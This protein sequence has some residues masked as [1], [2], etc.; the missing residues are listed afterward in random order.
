MG[1]DSVTL[2]TVNCHPSQRLRVLGAGSKRTI[3]GIYSHPPWSSYALSFDMMA[4][5]G[6]GGPGLGRAPCPCISLLYVSVGSASAIFGGNSAGYVR[7]TLF[8][9]ATGSTTTL[10]FMNPSVP[11]ALG[12]YPE[13]DNVSVVQTSPPVPVAEQ[14]DALLSTITGVGPGQSL[15]AKVAQ[16][17]SYY[18][19]PDIP[20]T[21]AVPSAFVNEVSAQ[22]GKKILQVLAKQITVDAQAIMT[23][24]GCQN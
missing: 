14:L 18:A 11:A 3:Q 1:R 6:Y 13:I 16:A 23:T 10:T 17:Q 24:I 2:G 7:E 15:A 5:T 4:Y 19:V 9:T 12:N 22:E 8:F 21:C 20:D